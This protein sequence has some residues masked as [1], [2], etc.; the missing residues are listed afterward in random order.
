MSQTTNQQNRLNES[1]MIDKWGGTIEEAFPNLNENVK[2]WLPIYCEY[3]TI[4]ENAYATLG[5]TQGMGAVTLPGQPTDQYGFWGQSKGSGDKPVSYLAMSMQIAADTIGFQ[6]VP[7]VPADS[8]LTFLTYVDFLYAGGFPDST[9]NQLDVWKADFTLPAGIEKGAILTLRDV[10]PVTVMTAV[11][12]GLSRLDGYPIFMTKVIASG[13]SNTSAIAAAAALLAADRQITD[14]VT[15][16]AVTINTAEALYVRAL[17]DH[18]AGFSGVL[19]SKLRAAATPA[20]SVIAMKFANMPY[21]RGEGESTNSRSLGMKFYNKDVQAETWTI[22]IAT[23]REQ[24]DDAR[25]FGFDV[26]GKAQKALVNEAIQSINKNITDRIF[27]LGAL[28]HKRI[29]D[30]S[31]THFNVNYDYTSGLGQTTFV[32]GQSADGS[33]NITITTPSATPAA[34]ATTG[35]ETNL[36]AQVRIV[37]QILAAANEIQRRGRREPAD[38]V[39]TN[40]QVCTMLMSIQGFQTAPFANTIRKTAGLRMMGTLFGLTIMMDPNLSSEDTRVAV[41]RKGDGET[42]G[43]I[44]MP[45]RIADIVD[46]IAENT[47]APK[48]QLKSRGKIVE[49]GHNPELYYI[50]LKINTQYGLLR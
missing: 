46:T 42:P 3:H 26:T 21:S 34:K 50:T 32:L 6:C 41:F 15:T 25:Q 2:S 33:G 31:G 4:N 11:F 28:N 1:R 5:N 17:E 37:Q 47:M 43:I 39:I 35:G 9:S 10:G 22:D 48:W 20:D 23:T 49:A 27:H 14:G 8:T 7:V 38:M 16:G 19:F 44:Y 36:T 12:L 45:Y 29:F 18:I 24:I 40:S 30:S 13:Y